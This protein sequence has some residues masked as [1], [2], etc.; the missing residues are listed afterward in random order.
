MISIITITTA[1]TITAVALSGLLALI[2]FLVLLALL[3]QKE[4]ATGSA[5]V[6][7]ENFRQALNIAIVP[8]MFVFVLNVV[9][10]VVE[11]LR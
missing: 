9:V 4:L 5:S 11:V 10:K 1:S 7:A 6:W 8:L 3:I 2:S